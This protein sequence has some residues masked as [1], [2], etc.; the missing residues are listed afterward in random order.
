M[1][2]FPLLGIIGAVQGGVPLVKEV[3]GLFKKNPKTPDEHLEQLPKEN[4]IAHIKTLE[5]KD[6]KTIL[7][8]L[9]NFLITAATVY[10][11]VWGAKHFGVTYQD[12][13]TLFGTL[14][15]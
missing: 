10:L 15:N 6:D 13:I 12:I 5:S 2:K 9:G 11:V 7:V 14:N 4:L 8:K 1:K 3:I